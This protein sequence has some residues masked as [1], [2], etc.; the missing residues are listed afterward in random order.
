MTPSRDKPLTLTANL[1]QITSAGTTS[2]KKE[3]RGVYGYGVHSHHAQGYAPHYDDHHHQPPPAHPVN[4]GAHFHTTVTKKI[5]IPIPYP[6][7]VK[8][9]L[10]F[11][12]GFISGKCLMCKCMNL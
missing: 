11:N 6:Y 4:L 2:S 9:G 12:F 8:V 7:P 3:K 1:G 5:G 10:I